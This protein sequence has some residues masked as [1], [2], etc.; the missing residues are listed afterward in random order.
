MIT[1][2]SPVRSPAKPA[3]LGA[4]R[5]RDGTVRMTLANL[6]DEVAEMVEELGVVEASAEL[7]EMCRAYAVRS[8]R[9]VLR[10]GLDQARLTDK[11][12][13]ETHAK[14]KSQLE[15]DEQEEGA[16][17]LE[18]EDE[19]AALAAGRPPPS[20]RWVMGLVAATVFAVGLVAL[21]GGAL[22]AAALEEFVV[23]GLLG[24]VAPAL[25]FTVSLVVALAL[26]G[27]L[28]GTQLISCVGTMGREPRIATIGG[29]VGK[30]LFAV[31]FAAIRLGRPDTHVWTSLSWSLFELSL[32]V[33]GA[34]ML[35]SIG[36]F[37]KRASKR[38]EK[39]DIV[40]RRLM[41]LEAAEGKVA[42]RLAV[43][44]EELHGIGGVIQER[45]E[46]EMEEKAIVELAETTAELGM[47]RGVARNRKKVAGGAG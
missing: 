13:V 23:R 28:L 19:E 33:V 10:P 12:V 22:L 18:R 32:L 2:K 37:L 39:E 5:E 46:A 43:L 27:A 1:Q 14:L 34:A 35:G 40:K 17:R 7:L 11:G 16:L 25:S 30:I 42:A 20:R 44:R 21:S 31:S 38:Q 41:R 8:V 26:V 6:G 3:P 24:E 47:L 45:E 4:R 36:A 9:M 15:L 29:W